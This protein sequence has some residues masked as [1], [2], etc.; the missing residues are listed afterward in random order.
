MD[1]P[2]ADSHMSLV[3]SYFRQAHGFLLMFDVTNY[4]SFTVCP[5]R[6]SRAAATQT[7]T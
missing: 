7:L 3:G 6:T 1:T 5:H 2:G 4:K